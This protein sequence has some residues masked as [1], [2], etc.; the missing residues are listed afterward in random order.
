[1]RQVRQRQPSQRRPA[2]RSSSQAA[3]VQ[4]RGVHPPPR[5]RLQRRVAPGCVPVLFQARRAAPARPIMAVQRHRQHRR[6]VCV[7]AV[8]GVCAWGAGEEGAGEAGERAGARN[9][10]LASCS[11]GSIPLTFPSSHTGRSLPLLPSL[12][13]QKK[14]PVPGATGAAQAAAST[15]TGPQAGTPVAAQG[16][17]QPTATLQRCNLQ[18]R[19]TLRVY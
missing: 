17:A 8:R 11:W 4:P 10:L 15:S 16:G 1:M 19:L 2:S 6:R 18:V 12:G 13:A 5:Q 3:A 7:I 9:W 14:Q